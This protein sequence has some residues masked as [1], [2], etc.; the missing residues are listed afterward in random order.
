MPMPHA[1]LPPPV[2]PPAT[3]GSSTYATLAAHAASDRRHR[4]QTH[5]PSAHDLCLRAYLYYTVKITPLWPATVSQALFP[6]L[7]S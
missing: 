7:P 5:P 1:T 2:A 4:D 6:V 3:A